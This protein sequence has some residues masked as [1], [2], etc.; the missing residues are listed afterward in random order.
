M[1]H[2][3]FIGVGIAEQE[4]DGG[5][6]PGFPRESQLVPDVS[7]GLGDQ[8]QDLGFENAGQ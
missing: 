8:R 5:A 2:P 6:V 1:T 3:D 7:V 4:S